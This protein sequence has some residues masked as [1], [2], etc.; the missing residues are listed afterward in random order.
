MFITGV[1]RKGVERRKERGVGREE[2]QACPLH[3][4][5]NVKLYL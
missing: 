2:E 4:Q 3:W 1:I 5:H